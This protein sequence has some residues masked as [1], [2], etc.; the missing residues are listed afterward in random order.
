MLTTLAK[1]SA[2]NRRSCANAHGAAGQGKRLRE[3]RREHKEDRQGAKQVLG[4]QMEAPT[5]HSTFRAAS[6]RGHK[7][8]S[9]H[10]READHFTFRAASQ[11]G[12]GRRSLC[13]GAHWAQNKAAPHSNCSAL[14]WPAH[15]SHQQERPSM[16]RAQ[17]ESQSRVWERSLRDTPRY[18]Q[19]G[20]G[21]RGR[22]QGRGASRPSLH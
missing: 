4:R 22:G 13:I 16:G 12:R 1:K 10:M 3:S 8:R 18:R 9:M 21:S 15:Q 17:E 6:Q 5:S 7:S 20:R 14:T 11:R 2:E 19:G